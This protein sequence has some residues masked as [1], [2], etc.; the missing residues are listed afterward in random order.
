MNQNRLTNRPW[1]LIA[2]T[3]LLVAGVAAVPQQQGTHV[4]FIESELILP[5]MP[6]YAAAESTFAADVAS[7]QAEVEALRISFD[8]A[9]GAYQQQE[10]MLSPTV[11][12]K[13]QT[14]LQQMQ[15]QAQT[16]EQELTQRAQE[17]N[18]ELLS[19]FETRIQAVIDGLRAE[20]NIGIIF[21]VSTPGNQIISADPSLNL[22]NVVI[23]RVTGGP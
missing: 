19:P 21:N 10:P 1:A 22:T 13:R 11:R 20:R 7:Y 2:V 6:G 5:Q 9:V 4:A 18:A 14:E 23:Q 16:R 17:R 3:V 8:S 15:Q 12:Q